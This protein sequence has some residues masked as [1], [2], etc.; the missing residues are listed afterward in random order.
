MDVLAEIKALREQLDALEKLANEPEQGP[1][2]ERPTDGERYFFLRTTGVIDGDVWN[3]HG[4]DEDRWECGN[5]FN[6]EEEAAEANEAQVTLTALRRQPGRVAYKKD[7]A[8]YGILVSD[9]LTVTPYLSDALMTRGAGRVRF[10]SQ[11][12]AQAAIDAVGK[13][14]IIKLAQWENRR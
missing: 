7:E 3:D 10:C 9:Q 6:T 4:V 11:E 5:V 8:A 1:F 14:H 13:E 2:T 12:A